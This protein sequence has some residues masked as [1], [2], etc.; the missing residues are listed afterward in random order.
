[1]PIATLARLLGF[2]ILLLPAAASAQLGWSK[3]DTPEGRF[4][5]V[6]PGD[7]G[8]NVLKANSTDYDSMVVHTFMDKDQGISFMVSYCDYHPDLLKTRSQEQLIDLM[9]DNGIQM[10]EGEL[11]REDRIFLKGDAGKEVIIYIDPSMAWLRARYFMRANRLYQLVVITTSEEKT[12]RVE[13][14]NFFESFSMR[15]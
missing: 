5:I 10:T 1:M 6:F 15:N 12:D 8:R 3:L 7:P 2:L 4:S 9:R 13:V 14:R 11:I